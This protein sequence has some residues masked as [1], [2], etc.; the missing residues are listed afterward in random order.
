MQRQTSLRFNSVVF[1]CLLAGPFPS[2]SWSED[3]RSAEGLAQY[4]CQGYPQVVVRG[5]SVVDAV[6]ICEGV[7]RALSFLASAGLSPPAGTM[8]EIVEKLPPELGDRALGCYLRE[9]KTI[10]LLSHERFMAGGPWFRMPRDRELYRSLA[11]HE[12]AHAVVGCHSGPAKL[13]IPAHEYVAYVALFATMEPH[14]RERLLANFK[15]TGFRST[16]EINDI[17]HLIDPSEF[18]VSAWRHYLKRPDKAAWLREV[19]AGRVVQEWPV[20]GP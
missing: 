9:S 8:I 18:G 4:A 19:V 16:L 14:L 10:Q 3:M 6:V 20:D 1:A 2:V 15:G 5:D 11:S 12:M 13:P 7:D 17:N